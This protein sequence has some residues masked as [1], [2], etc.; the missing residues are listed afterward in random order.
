VKTYAGGMNDTLKV[1]VTGASGLI[2]SALS[3]FLTHG[4]H[5]VRPLV[6]KKGAAGIFWDPSRGEIDGAA[7]EGIDV[8]VHL[9]GE[10]IAAGRWTPEFKTRVKDSRVKGTAL[11]AKTLAGLKQKPKVF[12]SASAVGYYGNRGDTWVDESSPPGQGFLSEICMD[13][14]QAAEPAQAAGIRTVHPRF[15][16]VLSRDGGALPQLM[17]PL[18]FGISPQIGDG[19]QYQAWVGLDDV[20]DALDHLLQTETISGPVNVSSQNPVPQRELV[21]AIAKAMHRPAVGAV[22]VFAAGLVFG[23]EKSEQLFVWSQRVRP[24]VLSSSGFTFQHETIEA[25]LAHLIP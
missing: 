1:A 15:G 8:V 22:P 14:E 4:G 10:S 21:R 18:S 25:C 13:W 19:S 12:V 6:R 11:L 17:Q 2:G 5:T 7:L 24:N 3:R 9:A 20:V 16:I 23:K